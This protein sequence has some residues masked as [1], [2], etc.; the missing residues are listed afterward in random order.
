MTQLYVVNNDLT[1]N[2]MF[3]QVRSKRTENI[4]HLNINQKEVEDIKL[5]K[6]VQFSHSVVSASF[7]P[8]EPQHTRPPGPSPPPGVHPDSRSLSR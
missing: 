4:D 6:V 2:I 7:R 1:L 8:C 3:R 5:D